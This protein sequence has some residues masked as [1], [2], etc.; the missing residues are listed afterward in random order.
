MIVPDEFTT[1]FRSVIVSGTIHPVTD[2]NEMT[3]GLLLLYE[4]YSPG[5]NP[6]LIRHHSQPLNPPILSKKG[7]F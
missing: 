1:H 3:I 6:T 7:K 5:I 4:K 2:L